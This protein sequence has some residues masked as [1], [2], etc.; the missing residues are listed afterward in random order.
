[1]SGLTNSRQTWCL[2]WGAASIWSIM[3]S[4]PRRYSLWHM[5]IKPYWMRI[6]GGQSGNKKKKK[7]Q[8][9]CVAPIT[10]TSLFARISTPDTLMGAHFRVI[11]WN[12][13]HIT[14]WCNYCLPCPGLS[15]KILQQLSTNNSCKPLSMLSDPVRLCGTDGHSEDILW[16]LMLHTVFFFSLFLSHISLS[17][18]GT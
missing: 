14:A 9:S 3:R 7:T 6:H 11:C 8:L 4:S 18:H 2:E 1:M 12:I 10:S 13:A 17:P 5:Q 15:Y 16:G